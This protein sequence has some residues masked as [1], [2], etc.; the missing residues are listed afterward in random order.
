MGQP[1]AVT[2]DPDGAHAFVF[3]FTTTQLLRIDLSTGDRAVVSSLV[4]GGGAPMASLSDVCMNP[5]GSHLWGCDIGRVVSV[6]VVSGVRT[7]VTSSA[8][9][10]QVGKGPSTTSWIES[11]RSDSTGHVLWYV[12]YANA[13]LFAVDVA[14]GERVIVSR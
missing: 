10:V 8:N 4:V 13:A 3:D 7:I 11:L 5:D 14:T 2:M 9:S 6:D 1:Y 12:D